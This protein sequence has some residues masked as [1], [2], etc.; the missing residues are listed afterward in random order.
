[1]S[2]PP[3]RSLLREILAISLNGKAESNPPP[4][5]EGNGRTPRFEAFCEK[6]GAISLN[7]SGEMDAPFR[8]AVSLI[9]EEKSALSR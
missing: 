6:I 9:F 7:D 4:R 5:F 8:V 2:N 1:M 3:F